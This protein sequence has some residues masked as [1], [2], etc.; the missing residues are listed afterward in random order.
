LRD[1]HLRDRTG[2]LVLALRDPAGSFT[3][4][5]PPETLMHAGHILI[6]IGTPAQLESLSSLVAS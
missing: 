5:P 1:S 3:T 2:A 6:A 4:N